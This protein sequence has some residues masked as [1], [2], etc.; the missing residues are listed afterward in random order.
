[1][2]WGWWAI[3]LAMLARVLSASVNGIEAFPVEVEVNSEWYTL[4]KDADLSVY[5]RWHINAD[6]LGQDLQ[7]DGRWRRK[8]DGRPL[9][10]KPGKYTVRVGVSRTPVEKRTGLATSKPIKFEIIPTK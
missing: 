7:L 1:M 4:A 9:E 8:S 5:G 10:L 6:N 3:N 2:F